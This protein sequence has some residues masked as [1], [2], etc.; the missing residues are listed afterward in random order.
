MALIIVRVWDAE[1]IEPIKGF[2]VC[3]A[4]I[5]IATVINSSVCG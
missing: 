1:I 4:G 5:A 3:K 2:A